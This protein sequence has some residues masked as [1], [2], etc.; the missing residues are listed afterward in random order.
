MIKIFQL[1]NLKG[2]ILTSTFFASWNNNSMHEMEVINQ[3]Q[4]KYE[5]VNF[6]SVNLDY[7]FKSYKK[8]VAK[9]YKSWPPLFTH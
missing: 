1:M 7:N 5:F 2:N 8:V 6:I 3:F 9:N 4:E